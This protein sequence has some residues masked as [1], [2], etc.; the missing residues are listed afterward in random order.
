LQTLKKEFCP[1]FL[2]PAVV[3]SANRL[4]TSIRSFGN[5]G[6]L[7]VNSEQPISKPDLYIIAR[8]IKILKERDK[9]NRTPLATSTGLSYDRLVK[10][11]AWMSDK[12]LV[13]LDSDDDVFLTK[14]GA[15]TYDEF[16]KWILQ[17]VGKVRFPKLS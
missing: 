14:L 15:D 10:Y 11:L 16:V 7:T 1:S 6:G 9:L 4:G 3:T 8:V 5:Y 17:Y 12:G 13:Q 2:K